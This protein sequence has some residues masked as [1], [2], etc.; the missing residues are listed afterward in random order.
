MN[1]PHG[2]GRAATSVR[3]PPAFFALIPLVQWC[4]ECLSY[5]PKGRKREPGKKNLFPDSCDGSAGTLLDCYIVDIAAIA[6]AAIG[7]IVAD[8][9]LGDRFAAGDV[10]QVD[11]DMVPGIEC[12]VSAL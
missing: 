9:D 3:I 11:G 10:A 4:N 5:V 8:I 7:L 2:R 12:E 1:R 6:A